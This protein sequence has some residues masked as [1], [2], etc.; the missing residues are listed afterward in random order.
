MKQTEKIKLFGDRDFGGNFDMSM[1]FIKQNYVHIFKALCY[2]TPLAILAAF[3][4]PNLFQTYYNMSLNRTPDTFYSEGE[5]LGMLFAY[6]LLMIII[7][8]IALY[9][10]SYMALYVKSEDGKVNSKDVWNKVKKAA[11]PV[12]GASILYGIAVSIGTMLCFIPGIIVSIYLIFY[13]YVY[14]NEDLGII[15]S[16]K[17]SITLV[18][19]NWWVTF[20][21]YLVT[22]IIMSMISVIFA[23]PSYVGMI[24]SSLQVEF[25]ASSIFFIIAMMIAF[26]GYIFVTPCLFMALGVMYY[27]HVNKI[28]GIDM[29]TEID[30]IGANNDTQHNSY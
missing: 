6:P 9:T 21:F 3:L 5:I 11:L 1:G 10:I 2:L 15:D 27:S 7:F 22:S 17:Y 16:L 8:C 30:S 13:A 23:I 18:Q 14:I 12:L 19:H 4:M 28:E 20:G 24:G 25:L 29:Q 26:V